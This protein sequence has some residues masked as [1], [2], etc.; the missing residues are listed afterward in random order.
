V[1]LAHGGTPGLIA[2]ITPLVL[3]VVGAIVVWRRSR[4]DES[5][6]AW[7]DDEPGVEEDGREPE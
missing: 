6:A 3:L 2:E 4:D 1:V 7:P 5:E